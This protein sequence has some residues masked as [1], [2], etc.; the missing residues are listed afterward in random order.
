MPGMAEEVT[1]H[2]AGKEL[3]YPV[4]EGTEGEK[5]FDTRKLRAD[6]G[7]ITFDEGYGNT[8]SCISEITFI[9]GEKGILRHRGYPIE[10]L[11]QHSDFL[12]TAFLIIYGE[13]PTTQE[14][15]A[16]GEKIRYN[17]QIHTGLEHHFDGFPDSAHPM[18]I[19][20][21]MLNALGCYYPNM[22]SN[23]RERDLEFFDDAAALLISK[24]RT[25]A[26]MSYRAKLGLP[27]VYPKHS[28][29]YAG[30]FLH[31]MFSEPYSPWEDTV[32][33]SHALDLILLL[34]ADHEQNC[35]TSTVR[36]V[37]SS[38]ANLFASVSAGV[39]GL[40]GP[41]HGGANSAVIRM[42]EEIHRT[43]DDGS[44]FIEQAKSGETKMMGFG[45][46]V[47]KNYDPRAKILGATAEKL[48]QSLGKPDPLLDIARRLEAAALEDDYFIARKLYPNVDFYSGIILKAIGIPTQLFPVIFAIGRMPGWIANWKELADNEKSRIHRPRQI[49]NGPAT[50]D[51]MDITARKASQLKTAYTA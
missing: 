6:T 43:G 31:M 24:V 42:L 18:A 22:T 3:K 46:R 40:W 21:A 37:A 49:Y 4:I 29:R 5:A 50:R 11:A 30:N 41:L 12:E 13:L 25:I 23:D 16:F 1:I 39:C 33:L 9:D 48:L 19:L 15:T 26:A 47:Y 27:F 7:Y 51:Y 38:N 14:R 20:S 28:L 32:G 17:S 45:H 10:Q 36:M 8:G 44:R 35:S 34:H 2:V